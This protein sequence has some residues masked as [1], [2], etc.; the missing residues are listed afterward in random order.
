MAGLT[1][2]RRTK[3]DRIRA[4]AGGAL[5]LAAAA[6]LGA[7][8]AGGPAYAPPGPDVAAAIRM[9]NTLAFAPETVT[10]RAGGIVEWRNKSIFT[11]T[12]TGDP[13]QAEQVSLPPGARPFHSGPV[14]PGE[15]Y[16]LRFET[17]GTYRYVCLPHEGQG[18]AATIIVEPRP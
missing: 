2:R 10:V 11:H 18:M 9:T 12:A 3:T 4:L 16:R 7:C 15:T 14:P 6:A 8:G 5:G 13:A 17:P 1:T